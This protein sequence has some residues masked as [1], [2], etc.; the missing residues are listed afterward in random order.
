MLGKYAAGQRMVILA[1]ANA[2]LG[3]HPCGA[4]GDYRAAETN[5]PGYRFMEL[6]QRHSLFAPNTFEEHGGPGRDVYT[7]IGK[8]GAMHRLD[9]VALPDA[10]KADT[11]YGGTDHAIDLAT[12]SKDHMVT[13]ADTVVTI[14][15]GVKP[16][17][18]RNKRVDPALLKDPDI[19]TAFAASL[20][21]CPKVRWDVDV[22]SH[23]D[24]VNKHVREAMREHLTAPPKEPRK[25]WISSEAWVCIQERATRHKAIASLRRQVRQDLLK[26]VLKYWRRPSANEGAE[27]IASYGVR[28]TRRSVHI[29][30][31]F[32]AI[33]VT[34]PW[35]RWRL[36]AD[37]AE[38]L[39]AR[40]EEGKKAID[41]SDPKKLYEVLRQ[42]R[43]HSPKAQVGV[44]LKDGS[45][46]TT[47]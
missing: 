31:H 41:A 1:D 4:V 47:R 40:I 24:D 38:H 30:V 15:Q 37:K 16:R 8:G 22:D 28:K 45:M 13:A 6:M 27:A 33:A 7:W 29:A 42:L 21:E 17:G 36:K 9:Y 2:H 14:Q 44:Q 26:V 23:L 20:Q 18:K 19:A 12:K 11:S 39:D 5:L 3:Q 32:H 43:A 25:G 35:L 46:A 10:W 34:C